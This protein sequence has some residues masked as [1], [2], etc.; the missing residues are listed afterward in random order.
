MQTNIKEDLQSK[1]KKLKDFTLDKKMSHPLNLCG[2]YQDPNE[3]APRIITIETIDLDDSDI[4]VLLA[5]A[6]NIFKLLLVDI[7]SRYI[8]G[9]KKMESRYLLEK[10]I[11]GPISKVVEPTFIN[12]FKNQ[13]SQI[14]ITIKSPFTFNHVEEMIKTIEALKKL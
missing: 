4:P 7:E 12:K 2:G 14:G 13:I 9:W 6:E 3:L 10:I 1:L 11:Q 5:E 8:S